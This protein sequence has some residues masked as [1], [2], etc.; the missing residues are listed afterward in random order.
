MSLNFHRCLTEKEFAKM[1]I[2]RNSQLNFSALKDR[3]VGIK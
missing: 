1:K 2:S 3:S